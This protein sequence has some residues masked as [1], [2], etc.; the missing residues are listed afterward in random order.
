MM[1]PVIFVRIQFRLHRFNDSFWSLGLK[2]WILQCG[3]LRDSAAL[4]TF[5]VYECAHF[6]FKK[7]VL[8]LY[9]LNYLYDLL[10]ALFKSLVYALGNLRHFWQTASWFYSRQ[11]WTFLTRYA[12]QDLIDMRHNFVCMVELSYK[13]ISLRYGA[14]QFGLIWQFFV[15]AKSLEFVNLDSALIELELKILHSMLF[16]LFC[17]QNLQQK[18][19]LFF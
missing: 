16:S 7:H 12:T 14:L 1:V 6:L 5:K 19:F 11:L 3:S 2:F 18:V 4:L 8:R 9:L 10:S 15:P 13:L 17:L